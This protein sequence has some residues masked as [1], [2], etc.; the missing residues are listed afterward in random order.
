MSDLQ[1][2][3][4]EAIK[5]GV[6]VSLCP[7]SDS[8]TCLTTNTWHKGW[9]VFSDA[10]GSGSLNSSDTVLR[11]RK[12]WSSSDTFVASPSLTVLSFSRDGFAV[13]LPAG[14]V[15]MPL[16]TSPANASTTKCVALNRVGRQVVQSPGTGACT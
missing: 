15:T 4:S 9:I 6:Q 5:R 2:T 16:Q 14:P 3:R 1:F 10:D 11:V 8:A 7:S 12:G 13:K